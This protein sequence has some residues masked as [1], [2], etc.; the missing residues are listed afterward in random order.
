MD[1]AVLG[2]GALHLR[3][4]DT[5]DPEIVSTGPRVGLRGAPDRPWRFWLAGERTVS[6]Y[7][8]AAAR[9]RPQRADLRKQ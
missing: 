2:S 4:G 9:P 6:V 5:P 8:P 3:L 1:G 7:R